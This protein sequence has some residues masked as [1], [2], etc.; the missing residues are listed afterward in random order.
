MTIHGVAQCMGG[1]LGGYLAFGDASS[2]YAKSLDFLV[3]APGVEPRNQLIKSGTGTTTALSDA[4]LA[5]S[6]TR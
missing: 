2:F 3:G 5:A 4:T 1:Y 6:L